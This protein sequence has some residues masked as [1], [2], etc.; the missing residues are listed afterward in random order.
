MPDPSPVSGPELKRHGLRHSSD[1]EPGIR[2]RRRGK[3]FTFYDAAG[4]RITDPEEIA[5]CNALAVPPAY[6]DVWICADP[7]HSVGSAE[8]NAYLHDHTGDDFTAKDFRT[9][10]ATVMAY[11]ALCAAPEATTKKERQ[12]HLKAAVAQVA[13]R[14]R[15][16]QAICRKAYVHPA[17][18]AHWEI[19]ELAAACASAHA[20]ADR[21]PEGLRKEER[22]VWVFLKEAEEKAAQAAQ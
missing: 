11:H 6:R 5:R 8:V 15:N 17:V 20:N 19:G 9:W 10:A 7:R 12:S 16:T 13:D 21:A 1:T 3:G 4:T 2:R 22:Q 18:I 14:L